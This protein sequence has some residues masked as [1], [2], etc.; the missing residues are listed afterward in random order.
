M[1][2]THC[3]LLERLFSRECSTSLALFIYNDL[4]LSLLKPDRTPY[5]AM[6]ILSRDRPFALNAFPHGQVPNA[7]DARPS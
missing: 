2:F 6:A 4:Y 5:Y 1:T 7:R 3:S